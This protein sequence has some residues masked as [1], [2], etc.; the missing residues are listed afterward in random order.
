MIANA[1]LHSWFKVEGSYHWFE[2]GHGGRELKRDGENS[3][4]YNVMNYM[5]LFCQTLDEWMGPKVHLFWG[6]IDVLLTIFGRKNNASLEE[7]ISNN[8]MKW[9]F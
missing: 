3:K 2:G 9:V 7:Y 8:K 6:G 5:L 1:V 4:S